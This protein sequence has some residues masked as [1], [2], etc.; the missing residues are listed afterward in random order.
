[1][2]EGKEH[3][4]DACYKCQKG[5]VYVG[6]GKHITREQMDFERGIVQLAYIHRCLEAFPDDGLAS[7]I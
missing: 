2:I 4:K 3:K 7:K 5:M 1:M 6:K